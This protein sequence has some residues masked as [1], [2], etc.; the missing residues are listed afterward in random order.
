MEYLIQLLIVFGLIV[1][2]YLAGS[3][4]EKAHYKKIIIR[5]KELAHKPVVTVA[6]SIEQQDVTA[7]WLVSGNVVVSIDY[8]KRFAAGIRNIFGGR[9]KAYETLVDRGRREAV[10]RLKES[11]KGADMIINMRIETS[12][13]SSNTSDGAIGSIEVFAYGTAV[14]FKT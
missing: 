5:E 13:I 6:R 4:A 14:K 11:A 2:G 12:S 9:M 7:S 1:L 8:F 10:L 3:A